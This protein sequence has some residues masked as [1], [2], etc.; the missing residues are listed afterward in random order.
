MKKHSAKHL[1]TK[2]QQ[3]KGASWKTLASISFAII[4]GIVKVLSKGL[5]PEVTPLSVYQIIFVENLIALIITVMIQGKPSTNI[6]KT[7]FRH[8]QIIRVL[9]ASSGIIIWYMAICLIP[10]T[11][12]IALSFIGPVITIIGAHFFLKE[13]LSH[14]RIISIVLSIVGSFVIIRPDL[15]LVE[16]SKMLSTGILFLLPIISTIFFS[17]SKIIARKLAIKG[18]TAIKMTIY[19]FIALVPLSFVPAI[20]NWEPISIQH[21]PLLITIGL[22]AAASQWMTATSYTYAHINFLTPFSFIRL[23]IG[24]IIGWWIFDENLN[25]QFIA[26][27]ALIVV[28]IIILTYKK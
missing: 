8:L 19:I 25:I 10:I 18:E 7:K 13:K 5:L 16:K 4:S 9:F 6:F 27:S 1:S 15:I 23:I 14:A 22:L 12:A 21:M 28:S 17:G 26:G 2:E 20:I 3:W 24:T 11:Q